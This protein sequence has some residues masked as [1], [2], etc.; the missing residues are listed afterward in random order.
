MRATGGPD[1]PAGA[2][3]D[4]VPSEA[5]KPCHEID[6]R[7]VGERLF[8]VGASPTLGVVEAQ[9]LPED[10]PL[11]FLDGRRSGKNTLVA[12]GKKTLFLLVPAAGT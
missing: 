3:C 1:K 2:L 11:G 6:K 8:E 9:E 7:D 12:H 10:R 4:A 5:V